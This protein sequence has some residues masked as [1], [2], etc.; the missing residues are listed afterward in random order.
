MVM[1]VDCFDLEYNLDNWIK[2]LFPLCLKVRQ[3]VEDEFI[4]PSLESE[5]GRVDEIRASAI[6]IGD[7]LSYIDK[8]GLQ[9]LQND[10]YSGTR[11]AQTGVENMTRYGAD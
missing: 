2:C 4:S 5:N 9:L 11:L 6:C 8:V 3:G 1:L 7:S 10:N